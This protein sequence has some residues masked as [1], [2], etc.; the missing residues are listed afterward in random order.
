[1]AL[2]ARS[3]LCSPGMKTLWIIMTEISK[4][5]LFFGRVKVESKERISFVMLKKKDPPSDFVC[6][7]ADIRC[8][9][10]NWSSVLEHSMGVCL[11]DGQ[12]LA[13]AISV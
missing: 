13:A 10:S 1:M 8:L 3:R 2:T 11:G 12:Y 6:I 9:A 7:I 5:R 4:S